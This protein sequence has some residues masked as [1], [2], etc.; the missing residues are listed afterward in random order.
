MS[1]LTLQDALCDSAL[2]PGGRVILPFWGVIAQLGQLSACHSRQPG[3]PRPGPGA[4]RGTWLAL[5]SGFQSR[6]LMS[7]NY[8]LLAPCCGVFLEWITEGQRAHVNTRC[9]CWTA[10]HYLRLNC[11]SL[12][13]A[14]P[15]ML[16]IPVAFP[17]AACSA[18]DY[19]SLLL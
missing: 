2:W 16:P 15:D 9:V 5:Y 8:G 13:A 11:F 17:W 10:S 3:A 1:L 4:G 6:D 18:S 7:S 14:S 12:S 19:T